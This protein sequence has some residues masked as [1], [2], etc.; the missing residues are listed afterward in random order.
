[1]GIRVWTISNHE[2]RHISR[3][4]KLANRSQRRSRR[5]VG[6][7]ARIG[8]R[9]WTDHVGDACD[10]AHHRADTHA[11]TNALAHDVAVDIALAVAHSERVAVPVGKSILCTLTKVKVN[12]SD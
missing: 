2:R 1:M 6:S 12:H 5:F 4:N 8:G 9:S 3:E 7:G 10:D 11:H